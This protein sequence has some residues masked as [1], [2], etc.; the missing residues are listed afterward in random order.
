MGFDRPQK[1]DQMGSAKQNKIW[2][3]KVPILD[4]KVTAEQK[5]RES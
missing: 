4:N 5:R 1:E 3:F 2:F